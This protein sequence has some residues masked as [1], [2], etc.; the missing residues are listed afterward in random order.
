MT[1]GI[2]GAVVRRRDFITFLGG[3]VAGWPRIARAQRPTTPM[4]GFLGFGTAS[5]SANRVEAFR[6]G[7]RELGYVEGKSINIEFR[8]AETADELR[9]RAAELVRMNVDVIFAT[10]STEVG[11][12]QEVTKAIPIIFATHADPIGTGHV[13][14]LPSP[15]GNIT[16]LSVMQS[17]LT[18]KA[19]SP[20]S[21]RRPNSRWLPQPASWE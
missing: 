7:L 13:T 11:A 19:H 10:S 15:G 1:V 12:A 14:S 20:S 16:G 18:A 9:D 2:S 17:D 6:E 8:W 3:A 21:R 5:A 4:V